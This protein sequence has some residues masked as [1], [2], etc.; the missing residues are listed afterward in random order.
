MKQKKPS[1]EYLDFLRN[2]K[3]EIE[4]FNI[5]QDYLTKKLHKYIDYH[6]EA[7]FTPEEIQKSFNGITLFDKINLNV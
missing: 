5:I 3:E 1:E 7:G 2:N 4:N 6:I